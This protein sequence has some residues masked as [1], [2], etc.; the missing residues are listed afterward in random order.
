MKLTIFAATGGIGR[1]LLGQAVAAGHDVT[2]VARNLRGLS[3]VPAR[4]VAAD[5]AS[6]DPAALQPAVAGADA[7]LSALGPRTKADAGVAARGTEV[8]TEAMRAA[9]VRRVIVVSAAPI[10]TIASP[11]RPHP[12]RHDPGDG[13]IIRYLADP[14]VKRALRAHYA[15]LAR[16]EDVLRDSDSDL[17]WTIVRPPRLTDKPV[18]GRYRTAYGQNIRRGVFV[19]RA[20]VAHYMLSVLDNPETFHRTVGIAN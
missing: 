3:P 15:D 4:A 13:F 11:G 2:A 18:T 5:L 9:G 8:I 12:P 20:D 1:Q 14:I 10:G 6:A 16:M 7:V 17:D 19:S